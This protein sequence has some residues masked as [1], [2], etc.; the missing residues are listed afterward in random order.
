MRHAPTSSW[1]PAME[2]ELRRLWDAGIS[3]S[4]IGRELGMT[5][6]S[7]VGKAHRLRLS[8]RPSPTRPPG[9]GHVPKPPKQKPLPAV[10][11]PLPVVA[12]KPVIVAP[13]PVPAVVIALPVLRGGCQYPL[14]LDGEQPRFR[15]GEP[16]VCGEARERGSYCRCHAAVC[17]PKRKMEAAA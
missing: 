9:A 17:Y 2:S 12:V 5:K 1:T 3:A 7:V 10:P 6:N 16:L 15:D 11:A 14:W 4:K 8:D 13:P